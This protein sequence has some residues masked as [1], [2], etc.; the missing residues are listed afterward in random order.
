MVCVQC[1]CERIS[2]CR[3]IKDTL[4]TLALIQLNFREI[5]FSF[6]EL[7]TSIF[8]CLPGDEAGAAT[9]VLVNFRTGVG[10]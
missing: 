8:M 7:V 4:F 3:N 9:D 5:I 10:I 2:I 6:I 1:I